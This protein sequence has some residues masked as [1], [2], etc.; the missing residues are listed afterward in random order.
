MTTK[1]KKNPFTA[2]VLGQGVTTPLAR[3]LPK[4]RERYLQCCGRCCSLS[5]A[6]KA[7]FGINLKT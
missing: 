6:D 7:E 4:F 5:F 2:L 1:G 3:A